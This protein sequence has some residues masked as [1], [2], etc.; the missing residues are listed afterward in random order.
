MVEPM[1]SICLKNRRGRDN[2]TVCPD[3][4]PHT[5]SRPPGARALIDRSQVAGPTLSMTTSTRTGQSPDE[6]K[7]SAAPDSTARRRFVL[8]PR[9]DVGDRADALGERQGGRRHPAADAHDQHRLAGPEPAPAQHAPRGE[10]GERVGRTLGPAATGRP[11]ND[12]AAGDDEQLTVPSP[13][14]LAD[15]LEAGH[16]GASSP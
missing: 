14:L 7:A 13:A 3:V 11:G 15:D 1:I 16:I 10:R 12:V 2:S 5:T 4:P 9:R 8:V 6:S